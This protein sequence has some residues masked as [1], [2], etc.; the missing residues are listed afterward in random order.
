[1]MSF[2]RRVSGMPVCAAW[3]HKVPFVSL[4]Q[5]L[6][7]VCSQTCWRAA[8]L[9]EKGFHLDKLQRFKELT[10]EKAASSSSAVSRPAECCMA[11]SKS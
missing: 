4:A 11:F 8:V 1:M 7:A 6:R 10:L 9:K 5:R 3:L 2:S